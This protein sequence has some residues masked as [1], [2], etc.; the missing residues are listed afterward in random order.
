M[1]V[2]PRV[3]SQR[4]ERGRVESG[5][6]HVHGRR[7]FRT[8]RDRASGDTYVRYVRKY[9]PYVRNAGVSST[10]RGAMAP[11]RRAGRSTLPRDEARAPLRRDGAARGAAAD[12]ARLRGARPALDRGRPVRAARRRRRR[13]ARR[14]DARRDLPPVRQPGRVP[15]RDDGAR[16]RRRRLD[17]AARA[18]R[19]R[20]PSRRGRVGRGAVRRRVGARPA[21]RRAAAGRLRDAV[22]AVAEHG[23]LR[24]LERAHQRAEHG[25]ARAVGRACSSARSARRSSTSACGCARASRSPTSPARPPA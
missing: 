1:A 3:A 18:P 19:A 13:R 6:E 8:E 14:Q 22:G 11:K 5:R 9:V 12:Q 20:R 17:R 2:A 24:P 25:G 10:L 23:A 16:A 15:G 21:A 7:S 4:R